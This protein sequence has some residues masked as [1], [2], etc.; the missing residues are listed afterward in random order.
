[1]PRIRPQP[2]FWLCLPHSSR[3]PRPA[4][5]KSTA[6]G[7][8]SALAQ[9]RQE[10]ATG[11][12]QVT[13]LSAELSRLKQG[14][15]L[16][17]AKLEAEL[18][19]ARGDLAA[20]EA[21]LRQRQQEAQEAA[22]ALRAEAAARQAAQ[23]SEQRALS[24]AAKQAEVVESLRQV[25]AASSAIKHQAAIV[26]Q[27]SAVLRA[28]DPASAAVSGTGGSPGAAATAA[29]SA[30]AGPQSPPAF[31]AKTPR[32]K[33]AG[34]SGTSS[35]SPA[36]ARPAT[37]TAAAAALRPKS[38]GRTQLTA[39]AA[40]STAGGDDG[41][42]DPMEAGRA[43]QHRTL[44]RALGAEKR[45]LAEAQRIQR[46]A[47]AQAMLQESK[48]VEEALAA[49]PEHLR[50]L[51]LAFRAYVVAASAGAGTLAAAV[52]QGLAAAAHYR[53]YVDPL[54]TQPNAAEFLASLEL[55]SAPF[56]GLSAAV[57]L[58]ASPALLATSLH[59]SELEA[60]ALRG[61]Q[62]VVV[63]PE[64][65]TLQQMLEDSAPQASATAAG[66]GAAAAAAP[67]T[68]GSSS[69][70]GALTDHALTYLKEAWAHRITVPRGGGSGSDGLV[71]PISEALGLTDAMLCCVPPDVLRR[72][73]VDK[74]LAMPDLRHL[75]SPKLPQL[76]FV[77]PPP[78]PPLPASSAAA[79]AAA[80]S[81][82]PG[83]APS[84]SSPG[85]AAPSA[86]SAVV[87]STLAAVL[88][89]NKTAAV[90]T[91]RSCGWQDAGRAAALALQHPCSVAIINA[92]TDIPVGAIVGRGGPAASELDL[93]KASLSPEDIAVLAQALGKASPQLVG[94]RL[95]AVSASQP[96]ALQQLIEALK[97]LPQVRLLNGVDIGAALA[98]AASPGSGGLL[99]LS[100]RPLGPVVA[101]VLADRLAARQP[102]ESDSLLGRLTA[103]NLTSC[104]LG[105]AGAQQLAAAV[106][107]SGGMPALR[108]ACLADNGMGADGA[109]TLMGAVVAGGTAS[110]LSVLDLSLNALGD[111]GC[112][113]LA[114][115][116]R[117]LPGLQSLVLV[118][119]G[120]GADGAKALS[121]SL[122]VCSALEDLQLASNR[123]S[124]VCVAALTKALQ[125][126][127]GLRSLALQENYSIGGEGCRALCGLLSAVSS[128][129]VLNLAKNSVGVEGA[130]ALA[131]GLALPTCP[132][133]SLNLEWCKL[134][135]EGGEQL[136]AAL[137]TNRSLVDLNL[138]R[139]GLGDKGAKAVAVALERNAVLQSLDLRT[140]AIGLVGFRL[141]NSAL[142]ER[143]ATLRLLRMGGNELEGPGVAALEDLA[144]AQ[145]RA[146]PRV[147]LNTEV[148]N[149]TAAMT[150]TT[151]K[152]APSAAS[153][154][155]ES[156]K[157]MTLPQSGRT[158]AG[159]VRS[160][161]PRVSPAPPTSATRA[162]AK[163]AAAAGMS[164]PVAGAAAAQRPGTARA[165]GPQ[166]AAGVDS[167]S[168]LPLG[169]GDDDL[170]GA[171][172]LRQ[173]ADSDSNDAIVRQLLA[174]A[175]SRGLLGQAAAAAPGSAAQYDDVAPLTL[176]GPAASGLPTD[177]DLLGSSDLQDLLSK[178]RS[179]AA[180]AADGATAPK[181]AAAAPAPRM[182]AAMHGPTAPPGVSDSSDLASTLARY[183]TAQ[184]AA[185]VADDDYELL[186][187][188]VAASSAATAAGAAG[189]SRAH[190]TPT[191][192][193]APAPTLTDVDRTSVGSSGDLQS[194]LQ[195]YRSG[196]G[197]PA[198]GGAAAAPPAAAARTGDLLGSMA[199]GADRTTRAAAASGG[200]ASRPTSAASSES[201]DKL[202]NRYR[203]MP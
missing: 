150:T 39:A 90:L 77:F 183:R 108:V 199:A 60:A 178:Y 65:A 40:S 84:P 53:V 89:G 139:N 143:N 29:G 67:N 169:A 92:G 19:A 86:V 52:A 127:T 7:F 8:N 44:Q 136:L 103:L 138:A 200:G 17:R 69:S 100:A 112:R 30:R 119:N 174:E 82:S 59:R 6:D 98:A 20:A 21:E 12:S 147:T 63:A 189:G 35:K 62:L 88:S 190:Q 118:G 83:D 184:G 122:S 116:L 113:A 170:Y 68:G 66:D 159:G 109:G 3:K 158:P 95:G 134:R 46:R 43:A 155:P 123:L 85:E 202:I 161:Q 75:N 42:V 181:V 105:A 70:S 141:I 168:R 87:L 114:P 54:I 16:E 198:V 120:I 74:A 26:A 25:Q 18:A 164:T 14:W 57:V 156:A 79:G 110:T 61:C 36:R 124:D 197:G 192:A 173:S 201:L 38:P 9:A 64:G 94:V 137:A 175:Q 13:T 41:L 49:A 102:G 73:A 193:G 71:G 32:P 135:T 27:R 23:A 10:A 104:G 96:A 149:R 1:M 55:T 51:G 148:A 22:A 153:P 34:G 28:A 47:A 11:R 151:A 48:Q 130:R 131:A 126:L 187:A 146:V 165:S 166:T 15:T 111:A 56:V 177:D 152:A 97:R 185:P 78:P 182:V 142:R 81:R 99:D 45:A 194:L 121:P 172:P 171:A 160:S 101:A 167:A 196:A 31:S 191:A 154:A 188:R 180:G 157:T 107:S 179:G 76:K 33:S 133:L 162:T 5:V 117:Q 129:Q 145:R 195:R 4:Q 203:R 144:V 72:V 24:N 37:A 50:A 140:N 80:G 128:L 106:A 163:A 132:L 186:A 176:A 125:G 115:A 91:L 58:F 2:W 93:S